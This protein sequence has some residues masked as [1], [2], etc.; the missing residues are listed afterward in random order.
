MHFTGDDGYEFFLVFAPMLNLL[1][2]DNNKNVTN[3]ISTGVSTEKFKLFDTN[4]APTL[5]NLANGRV[6]LTLSDKSFFELQKHGGRGLF[7]P[8]IL[9]FVLEQQ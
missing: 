2:L 3:W 9:T 6:R 7:A 8:P 1:T 4:F 5:T